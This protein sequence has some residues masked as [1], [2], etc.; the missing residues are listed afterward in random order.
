MRDVHYARVA[1]WVDR[2]HLGGRLVYFRVLKVRA[3]DHAG[4]I[5]EIASLVRDR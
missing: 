5:F 4:L 1:D 3:A 2:T